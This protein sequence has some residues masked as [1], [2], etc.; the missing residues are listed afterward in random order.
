[1][2]VMP[3]NV[4]PPSTSHAV[5]RSRLARVLVSNG[6]RRLSRQASTVST[7]AAGTSHITS[8][9]RSVRP[10]RAR[11]VE[12]KPPPDVVDEPVS[13]LIPL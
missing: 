8:P 5:Q 12:S 6:S 11:L 4:A 2:P 10:M 7:R 3:A 9:P 13:R 1:M